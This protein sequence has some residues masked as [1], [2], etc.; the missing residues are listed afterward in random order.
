MLFIVDRSCYD[1]LVDLASC[2]SCQLI[3]ADIKIL[4]CMDACCLQ[5]LQQRPCHELDCPSCGQEFSVPEQ[6]LERLPSNIYVKPVVP[7]VRDTEQPKPFRR[8]HQTPDCSVCGQKTKAAKLKFCKECRQFLCLHCAKVHENIRLTQSHHVVDRRQCWTDCAAVLCSQHPAK[9]LEVVCSDCTDLCCVACLR[10]VHR[11]HNWRDMD[12][13]SEGF[14]QQLESDVNTVRSA[15]DRC[16]EQLQRLRDAEKMLSDHIEAVRSQVNSQRDDLIRA[17]DHEI[18]VLDE[19]MSRVQASDV[20]RLQRNEDQ[21]TKQRR[22][23]RCFEEFCQSVIESGTVHEVIRVHNSLHEHEAEVDEDFPL[24][25][26]SHDAEITQLTF[27]PARVYD[28][29][30]QQAQHLIGSLSVGHPNDDNINTTQYATWNQLQ[31]QLQQTLEQLAELQ[32]QAENNQ[33]SMKHLEEQLA[34]KNELLEKTAKELG[35]KT[36]LTAELEQQTSDKDKEI[37]SMK[38]ELLQRGDVLDQYAKQSYDLSQRITEIEQNYQSQL[39]QCELKLEKTAFDLCESERSEADYRAAVDTLNARVQQLEESLCFRENT[40][41]QMESE[42]EDAW[43]QLSEQSMII[44][45]VPPT[46][47]Q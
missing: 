30:P 36:T 23:L 7:A 38:E 19:E 3:T 6:G 26:V 34:E 20:R 21:I 16:D 43:Q 1:E 25:Q 47:G 17:I 11:D 8:P 39:H 10:D 41:Q 37:N 4:P 24:Q 33:M 40:E 9:S 14:R 12:E 29:L 22:I 42:L 27:S 35:E 5:C 28:F 32:Q 45:H 31:S 44:E 46:A 2:P 13:V 15:A 18:A